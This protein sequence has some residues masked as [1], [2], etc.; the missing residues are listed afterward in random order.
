[1]LLAKDRD[2]GITYV[3]SS[4]QPPPSALWG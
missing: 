1:L 3:G 4:M 2:H